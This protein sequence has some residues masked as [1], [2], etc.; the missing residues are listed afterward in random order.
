M[1]TGTPVIA[2]AVGALPE[3]VRHGQDGFLADDAAGMAS[4]VN[5]VAGLDRAQIRCDVIERFSA[6]R[7]ADG[8]ERIYRSVL[9][10]RQVD[11][12]MSSSPMIER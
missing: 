5:A 12:V 6:G 1:A 3:I 11:A 4:H 9:E 7:M 10:E 2:R 8:Y